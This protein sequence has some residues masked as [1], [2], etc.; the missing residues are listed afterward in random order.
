MKRG[1]FLFPV[2]AILLLAFG[3][4]FHMNQPHHVSAFLPKKPGLTYSA[5]GPDKKIDAGIRQP[6]KELSREQQEKLFRIL[7]DSTTYGGNKTDKPF[8]PEISFVLYSDSLNIKGV[9]DLSFSQNSLKSIPQIPQSGKEIVKDSTGRKIFSSYGFSI[10]GREELRLFC[11]SVYPEL[12]KQL[13][14]RKK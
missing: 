9:I 14:P 3:N 2:L 13:V 11:I 8:R 1:F 6:G 5:L 4:A 10:K 7:N 12:S